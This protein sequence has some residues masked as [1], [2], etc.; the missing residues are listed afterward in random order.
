MGKKLSPYKISKILTLYFQGYTETGIAHKLGI[1]Q[2]TVSKNVGKFKSLVEQQGIDSAA[3][4]YGITDIVESL[5]V[6]ASE[7]QE[8]NFAIEE[9][10][11]IIKMIKV[12]QDCGV[13]E[14]D[15]LD[16]V[17]ACAKMKSADNVKAAVELT[18]LENAAGKTWHEI[19]AE[20]A[21]AHQDLDQIQAQ[22]A[23]VADELKSSQEQLTSI[24]NQ[25]K[26]ADQDLAMQLKKV[27]VKKKQASESL[28]EHMKQVGADTDRLA[29]LEDLA[30]VLK[31]G[32]IS[33]ETIQDYI[34]RQ[35]LLNQAGISIDIFTTIVDKAKA[36]TSQD[37]GKELL[38]LLSDCG[39]LAEAKHFLEGQVKSLQEKAQ[40]L[41]Q[42]AEIREKLEGEVMELK[43]EKA[44]I[45]GQIAQLHGQ[46]NALHDIKSK[47]TALS[48]KKAVLTEDIAH[49]EG[50]QLA[51]AHEIKIKEAKLIDLEEIEL[52]RDSV[53]DDLIEI[54]AR[55]DREKKRWAIFESFL[56]LVAEGSL[57]KMEKFAE[58]LPNLLN[59]VR[60]G[61]YT[62]QV[63]LNHI[64]NSLNGHVLQVL[65]C[66]GCALRFI[67]DKPPKL[68]YYRC[69]SCT[70]SHQIIVEQGAHETLKQ[71]LGISKQYSITPIKKPKDKD[72]ISD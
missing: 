9:A 27:D 30:L 67:V 62:S 44:A 57:T 20:A 2:S 15:Y 50:R 35:Q 18:Q 39:S 58:V 63:L 49:L 1:D 33:N 7:L 4:E 11:A 32:G 38:Q 6:L 59:E 55:I 41:K 42:L 34:Q 54:E 72:I 14:E 40:N 45:A 8:T 31:E 46:K 53:L 28:A 16:L 64:L 52:R 13:K 29:L 66:T 71:A 36:A 56:G 10:K 43:A 69:S 47:V 70:S 12:F 68:G 25:K 37:G 21:I 19:V 65:K 24:E 26:L 51:L 5:H 48:E 61:K 60:R 22:L 3:E 23:I 17:K